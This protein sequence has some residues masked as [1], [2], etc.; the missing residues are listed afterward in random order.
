MLEKVAVVSCFTIF[1]IVYIDIEVKIDVASKIE[2]L[3]NP[4]KHKEK[5]LE[6]F[7]GIIKTSTT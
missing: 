4:L 3:V 7:A 2:S 5:L 1:K 6:V